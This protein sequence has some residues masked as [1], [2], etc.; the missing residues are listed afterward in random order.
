MSFNKL[1]ESSIM[2]VTNFILKHKKLHA[3]RR[4]NS[5]GFA[6]VQ[7]SYGLFFSRFCEYRMKNRK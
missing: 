7:I 5:F 4:L 1:I 2:K 6:L 3:V